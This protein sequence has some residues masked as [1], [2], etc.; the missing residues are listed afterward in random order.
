[1]RKL[2]GG[3][4]ERKTMELWLTSIYRQWDLGGREETVFVNVDAL[5][6]PVATGKSFPKMVSFLPDGKRKTHP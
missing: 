4:I 3:T 2:R 6:Q 1:M 5:V